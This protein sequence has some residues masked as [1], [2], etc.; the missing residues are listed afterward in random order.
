MKIIHTADWHL[1]KVV[2]GVS[3][4]EDQKY[5]IEQFLLHIKEIQPNVIIIAGDLYDRSI[6]P[7]E[8][9]QLLDQTFSTIIKEM[10]IPIVAI[11]GN[12]DS[13][14]RVDFGSMIFKE[15]NLHLI[16]KLKKDMP[17]IILNDEF[18]KVAFHLIPFADPQEVRYVFE[19]DSVKTNEQAMGK[20][21]EHIPFNEERNICIAHAFV[22]KNGEQIENTD[23]SERPLSI[24][25]S[26]CINAN[27]FDKFD[28]TALGHLHQA[29]FVQSEKIRYSGSPLKY[30]ISEATHQKGF[31]VVEID[32]NGEIEVEKVSLSPKR[33]MRRIEGFMQDIL[34][35]EPSDDYVYVTLFDETVIIAPME[36]IRSV[37]PNAMHVERTMNHTIIDA[38]E[39]VVE[40]KQKMDT[41][42]LFNAFY[43]EILNEEPDEQMMTLFN[44]LLAEELVEEREGGRTK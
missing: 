44:E 43:G 13:T 1:G 19:D 15:S 36:K 37:F 31:L 35:M 22:T 40:S 24:G 10:N 42:T 7:V 16:G 30:S 38:A 14:S 18:G 20:I 32:G 9:V 26:E 8:A 33:D 23:E 41:T 3:M 34:K 27:L 39:T 11:A 5:V 25:G 4:L 28:Y 12:H 2:Q 6:P 21:I 29:H 17:P